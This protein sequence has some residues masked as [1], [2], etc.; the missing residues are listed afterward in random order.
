MIGAAG[1]RRFAAG[2]RPAST[3]TRDRRCRS[4]PDD[5]RRR[6]AADRR[7][8]IPTPSGPRSAPRVCGRA[9]A[10]RRTSWPTRT[11]S[12]RSSPR[13]TRPR[14]RRVLE[15]GPGLGLLTGALLA[16][17]A[18]VTAV[19]LDRGLAAFLRER[20]DGVDDAPAHRGRRARPGPRPPR[21]AAVRRRRQP[22]VPHHQPDPA[23]AAG[24]A[25][26][27]G[28]ARPD[29]PA[30]GRRADRGAAREDELPVGLRPV[31]RP[32]PDRASGPGRRLRARAGGR[33]GGHRRRAVRRRRPARPGRPRTSCGG[34]SRPRFR[35]RRKMLHNV[36]S[37]QLPLDAG[38]VTAALA[39]AAASTPTDGRRRS[40]S[41]SGWPCARRSGR[42]GRTVAAEA[43]RRPA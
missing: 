22:A 7:G 16:A 11:S 36:L 9:T 31:P 26:A 24:H 17:G 40:R 1:A 42:S 43:G 19:E 10:C 34:S 20:F 8:S 4:R 3:S 15:I 37:R 13:P 25:A 28:A 33:I 5:R 32:G 12:T 30:R 35:E 2:E 38:R 29:G 6:P 27:A 21:R 39:A 23:R 14:A 18:E 41:G